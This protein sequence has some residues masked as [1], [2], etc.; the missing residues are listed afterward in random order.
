M[1]MNVERAIERVMTILNE[2]IEH[3][4]WP[5]EADLEAL[6]AEWP[7]P[8]DPEYGDAFGGEDEQDTAPMFVWLAADELRK[9][10]ILASCGYGH[11]IEQRVA[12]EFL[13]L[14]IESARR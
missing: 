3:S 4:E 10:T 9:V 2:A 5:S 8:D 13:K 14:A 11:T 6:L 12:F 1:R 7:R